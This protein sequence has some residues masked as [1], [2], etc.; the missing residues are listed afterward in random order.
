MIRF[1]L[2]VATIAVTA[3][4]VLTVFIDTNLAQF[5]PIPATYDGYSINSPVAPIWLEA[6]YD[7]LCP[8]SAATWPVIQDVLRQWG[9]SIWFRL[10]VFPLPYHHNAFLAAKAGAIVEQY[11]SDLFWPWVD[12]IFV[13]Q[14]LFYTANTMNQSQVQVQNGLAQL[15]YT[16]LGVP[17]DY[18]L[19]QM[20][21][22]ETLDNDVRV[23]WKFGASRGAFGTPQ[24][25][26]NGVWT[27]VNL[28]WTADDWNGLIN[29]VISGTDP[30][31]L[32][33]SST[34]K[35]PA[36]LQTNKRNIML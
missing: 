5:Q 31:L 22:N 13:N 11:N 26:L 6:Y 14:T 17:Q 18:F 25:A 23:A 35:P 4:L 19:D 21:N 8:D 15:V 7:F 12:M 2:Q 34:G 27:Q 10:H 36:F 28:T 9:D 24:F 1:G 30:R 20:N 33:H 32:R 29:E 3:I 16:T